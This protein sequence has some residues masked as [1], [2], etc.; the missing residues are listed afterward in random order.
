MEA[1]LFAD[2]TKI[3]KSDTEPG[4][5]LSK[6][7]L[8]HANKA[9]AKK[10]AKDFEALYSTSKAGKVSVRRAKQP[11][12]DTVALQDGDLISKKIGI[13]LGG[14]G[15]EAGAKQAAQQFLH[16]NVFQ[17]QSALFP[18]PRTHRVTVLMA[19]A[20]AIE[21]GRNSNPLYPWGVKLQLEVTGSKSKVDS[22]I[23]QFTNQIRIHSTKS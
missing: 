10:L 8:K 20:K 9:Q 3:L 7:V 15:H 14:Y 21:L 23:Q 4:S 6:V 12:V 16:P 11:I 18:D 2:L 17:Y 5:A 22:W 19:E 1:K 13:K